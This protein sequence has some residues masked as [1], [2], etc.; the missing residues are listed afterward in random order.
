VS[1]AAV[2]DRT[3]A[4][5]LSDLMIIAAARMLVA[6]STV[7]VGIGRPN[8]A[9]NLARRTVIIAT[10]ERRRFPERV[11][12][13]TSPGYLSGKAERRRLGLAGGPEAVIT[14]LAILRFDDETGEMYLDAVHPG[15]TVD[16]VVAET[17]WPLR[18]A[19]QIG[20]TPAPTVGELQT[21]NQLRGSP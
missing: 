8:L 16:R 18:L 2:G 12:F 15:V 7:L 3:G 6:A 13:V 1:D 10:H 19:A 5:S 14:N 4:W 21:L 17:G 9:A 20:E 11:D